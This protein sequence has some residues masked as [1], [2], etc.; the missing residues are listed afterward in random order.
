MRMAEMS[1][2]VKAELLSIGTVDV[3]PALLPRRSVS[4]AG[5]GTGLQSLFFRSGGRR[6][7]LEISP[8]SPLKMIRTDGEFAIVKDGKELAR[9]ELEPVVA[10]CPGQ[11]YI[12]V[13]E[14]CICDCTFCAVPRL[15]GRIKTLEEIEAI[16][17]TAREKGQL[18]VIALTSGIAESPEAEI[19]RVVGIVR[20]LKKYGVPIGV[21]VYPTPDASRRLKDA[22]ATEVKYNV[23]TMDREIFKRVCRGRKGLSLDAVLDALRDAVRVFGR[24]RVTSN[25]IIGL[26]E[27]DENVR[28]G[29]ELLASMG[30]IP[31]LRPITLSPYREGELVA[32]RPSAERLLRLAAMTRELLEKYGLRA[33]VSETMCLACTGCDITPIRDV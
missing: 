7:R 18:K 26:G 9:G 10:H 20:A 14:R 32:T 30:V 1:A 33:D 22:G 4:A 28:E 5:P 29:V 11:V 8:A 13:S 6:I 23:E 17:D 19:D 2:E 27:T 15:Q 3:D 31:V 21:S 12:T 25:I 24:N 16:V